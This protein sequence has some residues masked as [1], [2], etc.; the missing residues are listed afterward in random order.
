[1]RW[2]PVASLL[3]SLALSACA[4]GGG[5]GTGIFASVLGNVTSVQ[6]AARTDVEGIRV[7]IE[8]TNDRD[9]TDANGNF[10]VTGPFEGL[11]NVVFQVPNGGGE[12]RMAL[13]VPAGGTLTLNNVSIDTQ[14]EEAT[15]ETLAVDFEGIITAVDC[16]A[17]ILTMVSS[18]ESPGEVDHY[19]LRLDTSSVRDPQGNLVPC[20]E[21]RDGQQATVQ[22]FVNPDG[23]FGDATVQLLN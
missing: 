17:L 14:Q 13:N 16:Q 9:R 23:T 15:A 2:K 1:M 12:G 11:V 22:G 21:L 5:R 18:H 7:S 19:F 8:G 6:T 20:E 3:L 10:A 4:E